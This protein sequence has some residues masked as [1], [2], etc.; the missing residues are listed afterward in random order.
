MAVVTYYIPGVG[1]SGRAG[2]AGAPVKKYF[3]CVSGDTLPNAGSPH[4]VTEG[5]LLYVTDLDVF[6]VWGNGRWVRTTGNGV[7]AT[8]IHT[9]DW[10]NIGDGDTDFCV[11]GVVNFPEDA[12]VR[13]TFSCVQVATHQSTSFMA[14]YFVDYYHGYYGSFGNLGVG[15]DAWHGVYGEIRYNAPA[16]NHQWAM[17]MHHIALTTLGAGTGVGGAI[18]PAQLLVEESP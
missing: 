5:D 6:Y 1:G 16:G 8:G 7:F 9:T 12:V 17:R 10:Q 11:T 4:F 13:L 18:M 14:L 3:T 2:E 15:V